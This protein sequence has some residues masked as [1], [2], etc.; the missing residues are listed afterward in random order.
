M[1]PSPLYAFFF[2]RARPLIKNLVRRNGTIIGR[3]LQQD[4][5]LIARVCCKMSLCAN[6][7]HVC[8]KDKAMLDAAPEV[9]FVFPGW[10]IYVS[11]AGK[12]ETISVQEGEVSERVI[13]NSVACR[14]SREGRER[15]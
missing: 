10:K 13:L 14:Y 3:Y 2:I 15:G 1:Y 6:S 11:E 12:K 7:R 5:L 4:C 9:D 8:E